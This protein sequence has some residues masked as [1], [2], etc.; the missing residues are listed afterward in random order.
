MPILAA[1]SIAVSYLFSRMAQ[2]SRPWVY[3]F[4]SSVGYLI[5]AFLLLYELSL[6]TVIGYMVIQSICNPIKSNA[7]DTYFY[8]LIGKL[9]TEAIVVRELCWNLGR[10]LVV[11][12]LIS[13]ASDLTAPW[14]PWV[15]IVA[16][17]SQFILLF[18]VE[19]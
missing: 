14:L 16:S 4:W 10:I 19:I 3:I 6:F 11:V 8:G 1:I 15:I 7:Y 18:F 17:A 2:A 13:L 12:F 9:R 5:A